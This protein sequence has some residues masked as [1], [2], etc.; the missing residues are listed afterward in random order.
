M[1][2]KAVA[3]ILLG[4]ISTHAKAEPAPLVGY[5]CTFTHSSDINGRN[6]E[7]MLLTYIAFDDESVYL[8]T[9][10]GTGAVKPNYAN[11]V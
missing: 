11:R 7:G 9:E 6:S 2:V 8:H 10:H 5:K 3:L 4:F 1:K